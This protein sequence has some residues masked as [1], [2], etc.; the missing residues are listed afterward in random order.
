MSSTEEKASKGVL[1]TEA[2]PQ[3]LLALNFAQV[4]CCCVLIP[5]PGLL[6][7]RH[8]QADNL[9]ASRLGVLKDIE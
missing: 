4:Y 1:R 2:Q 5:T 7:G 9:S 6:W 3:A 8:S